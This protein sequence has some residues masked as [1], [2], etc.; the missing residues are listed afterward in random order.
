MNANDYL[1]ELSR[2][3]HDSNTRKSILKEYA[4]H[5]ED[6]K[7]ALIASGK[8]PDDAELETI[9]QMGDPVIACRELNKLHRNYMDWSR[10]LFFLACSIAALLIRLA[11]PQTH[12]PA[13]VFISIGIFFFLFGLLWLAVEKYQDLPLFYAWGQNWNGGG[14]VNSG[15]FLAI[16]LFFISAGPGDIILCTIILLLIQTA[17]CASI[18]LH[19]DTREAKL[20]WLTGTA[21]TEINPY[22]KACFQST[23]MRVETQGDSIEKGTPVMIISLHGLKPVVAPLSLD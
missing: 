6:Q 4:D 5:I 17:V 11:V 12:A 21:F 16:G 13:I 7:A 10:L 20:L 3:I 9:H 22:G 8:T 15:I 1:K 18:T 19:K 2:Q 23:S 14:I